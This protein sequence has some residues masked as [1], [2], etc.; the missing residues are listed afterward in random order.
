M[1]FYQIRGTSPF[2]MVEAVISKKKSGSLDSAQQAW[3]L[4]GLLRRPVD[5]AAGDG[6][7]PLKSWKTGVPV[8][9][10]AAN[11]WEGFFSKRA[12]CC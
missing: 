3:S 1:M 8:W 7:T 12:E 4:T 6:R 5:E 9:T 11:V 2:Q 10:G